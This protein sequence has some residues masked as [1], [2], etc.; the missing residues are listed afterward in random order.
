[1][2]SSQSSSR[3]KIKTGRDSDTTS[4]TRKSSAY[5]PAFEQHLID[6]GVYPHGYDYD[7]DDD[8]GS[9]YPA[10][11][12]EINDRL[13]QPRPSLSPS[14]FPREEFRK[15]EKTNMQALTEGKVMSKVFPIIAG[16]A[17]IPTQENL[18]FGNLR[19]LNDDSITKAEPDFYDGSRP[20]DLKKC[21]REELGI[22]P[23]LVF[24]GDATFFS[25][26]ERIA[27]V[28][29]QPPTG[30][31]LWLPNVSQTE[32]NQKGA[33]LV[34]LLMLRSQKRSWTRSTPC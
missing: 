6:Y 32:P 30:S 4:R 7:D 24:L 16:T 18:P 15:F 17:D 23:T 22:S 20:A 11:W 26:L 14:R 9:V 21:I 5:D 19:N 3:K 28:E 10:N 34:I 29:K 2:S 13:A 33:I 1:M 25:C 31:L 12:K 8:E 27:I